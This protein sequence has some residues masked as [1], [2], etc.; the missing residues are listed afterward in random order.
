MKFLVPFAALFATLCSPGLT[1]GQASPTAS[2]AASAAANPAASPGSRTEVYQV[3]FNRAAPGKAAA[4]ADFLKAPG[5]DPATAGHGLLLRHEDGADWDY[6]A[7]QYMGTKA[8]VEA[9]GNP[10]S[11]SMKGLS[12]WHEDTFA[13][14]PSWSEFAKAMDLDNQGKSK[15]ADAVYVV[16]VYRAL[17]G[18]ED[19]LEKNLSE[20]PSASGDL[21]A[22]TV[23]LQHLE[24]GA[25]RYLFISRYK[26]WQEFATSEATS[27]AQSA[28]G[29][30]GWF[31]LREHI[32]FHNDTITYRIAP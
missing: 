24:G 11:P 25:W 27:V 14:G 21:A 20:P 29:T 10:R 6:L 12:D 5:P 32:S 18:H 16:S 4:L 2:P 3:H 28:K 23:L 22:G 15:S 9:T 8:T 7:V 31:T 26:S 19:A 17:P 1:Y 13:N 30:G